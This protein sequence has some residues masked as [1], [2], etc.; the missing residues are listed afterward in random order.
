MT[1]IEDANELSDIKTHFYAIMEHYPTVYANYKANPNL[2]SA[3]VNHD[4]MESRLTALY[5]RMFALQGKVGMELDQHET[6]MNEL[7]N[8]NVKLNTALAKRRANF[9]SND[10]LITMQ[11]PFTTQQMTDPTTPTATPTPNQISMVSEARDIK[12]TDYTYSIAR[13]GYLVVGI[14]VISYFI[15][16]TVGSPNS[17][18]LE[19]AKLK[20]AQLKNKVY[21]QPTEQPAA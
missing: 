21:T 11:E 16:Q 20:A 18:I 13:I 4:K 3:I 5:R 19:D 9:D 2:P 1:T 10:A 14:V 7:T 12:T 15:L 8:A 17:T 6:N